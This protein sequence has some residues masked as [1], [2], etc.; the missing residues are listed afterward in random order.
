[1]DKYKIEYFTSTDN[2]E[3]GGL[4]ADWDGQWGVG[5]DASWPGARKE[6]GKNYGSNITGRS[7]GEL[8][9]VMGEEDAAREKTSQ[10]RQLR[11]GRIRKRYERGVMLHESKQVGAWTLKNR[12]AR[13]GHA[14]SPRGGME[15][16]GR[17]CMLCVHGMYSVEINRNER[18]EIGA[19][20]TRD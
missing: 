18:G 11:V 3:V 4:A 8:R 7:R 19:L 14:G 12:P 13:A 2:K 9:R 16:A 5:G 10:G 17:A 1:M 20:K 6:N 15:T